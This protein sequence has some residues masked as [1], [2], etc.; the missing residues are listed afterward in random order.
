MA[1]GGFIIASNSN[2]VNEWIAKGGGVMLPPSPMGCGLN[3]MS[4]LGFLNRD[5]LPTLIK[6]ITFI[7]STHLSKTMI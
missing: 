6:N 5:E 2:L 3:V 1:S 4:C 7:L